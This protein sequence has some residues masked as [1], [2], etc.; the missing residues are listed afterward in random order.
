ML[1]HVALTAVFQLFFSGTFN[2]KTLQTSCDEEKWFDVVA[3]V[4]QFGVVWQPCT[5]A[6]R[7]MERDVGPLKLVA[8][9]P[10]PRLL[11]AGLSQRWQRLFFS[12]IL[13][14]RPPPVIASASYTS[15]SEG[16]RSKKVMSDECTR[17]P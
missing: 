11:L 10:T 4:L 1:W 17:R 12:S 15:R 3:E 13:P 9:M 5:A 6:Q 7:L 2:L 8:T 14:L 16:S